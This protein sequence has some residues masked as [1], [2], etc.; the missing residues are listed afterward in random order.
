MAV[1][2]AQ[3]VG[4]AGTVQ[5]L[6]EAVAYRVLRPVGAAGR[7]PVSV[8]VYRAQLAAADTVLQPV[9]TGGGASRDPQLVEAAAGKVPVQ[10]ARRRAGTA[11]PVAS[12][13]RRG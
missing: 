1:Y 6:A 13:A 3:P 5:Q 4:V 10:E 8:V 12:S 11:L 2:R 9:V 7:V